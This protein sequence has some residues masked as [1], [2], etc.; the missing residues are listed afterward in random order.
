MPKN[1][2]AYLG[3]TRLDRAIGPLLN[4]AGGAGG[5]I[6][7]LLEAARKGISKETGVDVQRDVI[8]LFKGEVAL[9]ITPGDAGADP[10]ASSPTPTTRPARARCSRSSRGRSP[11]CSR[12][13]ARGPAPCPRSRAATSAAA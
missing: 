4:L 12:Q 13:P 11:S 1:A 2:I 8:S 9:A 5:S 7:A 3:I 6:G 10:H